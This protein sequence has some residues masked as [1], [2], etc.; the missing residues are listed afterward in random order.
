M[1]PVRFIGE[2]H[3]K[4]DLGWIP[5][6]KDWLQHIQPQPWMDERRTSQLDQLHP[7]FRLSQKPRSLHSS[8]DIPAT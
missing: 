1:I 2:Q 5:T 8:S 4:D 6:V 7:N 3:V